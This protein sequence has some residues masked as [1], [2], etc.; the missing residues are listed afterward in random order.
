MRASVLRRSTIAL[1]LCLLVAGIASADDAARFNDLGHRMI[2]TCGCGQ[3][4]LECNHVGCTVSGG[5]RNE[6][7][8]ALNR[9]ESDGL[10]LQDFVQ[11]YGP[12]VLAAPTSSGFNLVA[13]IMP[14][15]VLGLGIV[16]VTLVVRNWRLRPATVPPGRDAAVTEKYRGRVRQETE[17]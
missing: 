6:L 1:L 5:M 15:V 3:I 11:H 4:L 10:I 14:F 17:F 16:G 12:T 9:S 2:C 13:W 8:M 7:T